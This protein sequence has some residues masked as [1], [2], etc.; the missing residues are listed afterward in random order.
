[1][2][3][4]RLLKKSEEVEIFKNIEHYNKSIVLNVFEYPFIINNF[5]KVF[6]NFSNNSV[7]YEKF[8]E[9][10][11]INNKKIKIKSLNQTINFNNRKIKLK[12]VFLTIN[13][14][15]LKCDLDNNSKNKFI[16]K[17]ISNIISLFKYSE[18]IL[19]YMLNIFEKKIIFFFESEKKIINQFNVKNKIKKEIK[20][21]IINIYSYY[22]PHSLKKIFFI[23]NIK[24]YKKI[25]KK[26]I[27]IKKPF[28]F[29]SNYIKRSYNIYKQ[30]LFQYRLYK[31]IMIESNIRLVISIA[32]NYLNR[33][34][35]FED[36][37][38][39][40]VL[41]LIK[42]VE[43]FNYKKG[44]KFSTYSTWWIRQSI[45]RNIADKS[46]VIRIPVHM[47]E[48]LSKIKFF[49]SSYLNKHGK[50]PEIKVISKH[51]GMRVEKIEKIIKVSK[52]IM[53]LDNKLISN[54]EE[55]K[56]EEIIFN[57]N[58]K[59]V[60]HHLFNKDIK[61]NIKK[62]LTTIPKRERQIIKMRFGFKCKPYT[63]EQIGKKHNVTRE[64]IRQI[65]IKA[66]NRLRKPYIIKLISSLLKGR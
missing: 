20:K 15:F 47:N 17:K 5:I 12:T 23:N 42:G 36:L 13:Y 66:I 57:K 44:F 56:V 19:N 3:L 25:N 33:G 10:Y 48:L 55:F 6:K 64:R 35:S 4:R 45:T 7:K 50:P 49:I 24:K 1:M 43:K 8:I 22:K 2:K 16:L 32:K 60:E 34:I 52:F 41:G 53:S 54:N 28:F 26:N 46:R 63:L 14:K 39:E 38:Q 9:Y 62:I 30:D 51:T 59:P 40:G 37:F 61:K 29:S 21:N 31:K 58:Q 65:E 27:L 11:Y 18:N